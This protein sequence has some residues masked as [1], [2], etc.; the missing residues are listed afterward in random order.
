MAQ[1]H[2]LD[3]KSVVN[4]SILKFNLEKSRL[5][6]A[7]SGGQDSLALIHIMNSLKKDLSL[8]LVVA[9]LNHNLRGIDSDL[10]SEFVVNLSN[11]FNERF[12]NVKS[13][14]GGLGIYKLEKILEFSYE[15]FNG[16][17]CEHVKFNKDINDKYGKLYID[18]KLINSYGINKHTI[19]GI[20]CSNSVFFA[21]RFLN[22]IK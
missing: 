4:K 18:Q 19:N 22:K 7:V 1:D 15:S 12:I 13:A 10:D 16:T 11:N 21:K 14:F 5:L 20:L 8:D 2:L 6:I 9:H 3:I 17:T